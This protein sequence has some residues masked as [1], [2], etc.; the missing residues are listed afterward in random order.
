MQKIKKLFSLLGPGFITGASDDDPTAIASYSQSGAQFGYQQL[1][2]SLFIIP[3]MIVTQE[4]CGRIGIVTGKG[5]VTLIKKNY[6]SSLAIVAVFCL[7]IAN[8]VT[9]GANI[10]A[11]AST[12]ATFLHI[13]FIVLLFFFTVLIVLLQIVLRYSTYS[14][15]LKYTSLALFTYVIT[16]FVTNPQWGQVVRFTFI[17]YIS[18]QRD[19]ILTVMA[20]LGTNL[21]PYLFFWQASEEVE[22]IV[23]E[24]KLHDVN[25]GVPK[26]NK[27]DLKRMKIDTVIGMVFSNIVVFFIEITAATTL[28]HHGIT[29]IETP[30]QAALALKPLAGNVAYLLFAIGIIGSGM[31]SIPTLSGS[32]AFA[33][34]EL[35]GWKPGLQK[36]FMKAPQFYLLIIICTFLGVC[37]NFSPI[38][39]FQLLI[40]AAALNGFLTPV[41]LIII[42]LIAN[43]KK[44]MK[45]YTNTWKTNVLG[46]ALIVLI[47]TSS[48][49]LLWSIVK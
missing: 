44:L 29:N 32:A 39:P 15:V 9:I 30:T 4:M 6:H 47:G 42:L 46:V 31:L 45:Q 11:I 23:E 20:I 18:L 16:V 34:S 28:H 14:N 25:K 22:E 3:F 2:I 12:V 19:F 24:K 35:A 40:Y 7:V 48:V 27:N 41:L 1:W 8:V 17:P 21:S 26:T 5:I 37:V 10:G 33:V 38:K 36:K 13:P 43:N 49:Y